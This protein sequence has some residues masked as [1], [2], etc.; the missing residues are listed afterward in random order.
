MT[1]D[2]ANL[3]WVN[4]DNGAGNAA[5]MKCSIAG[6]GGSPTALASGLVSPLAIATDG[7]NVYWTSSGPT[8]GTVMKC[9]VNG[10][11]MSPTMI[12]SGQNSPNSI[13]VDGTAVYWTNGAAA[14]AGGAVMMVMK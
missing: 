1:A 10:C 5:V 9:S 4:Q 3:Y 6:C 7:L 12:A 11:G 13:A 8:T 14:D 2:S